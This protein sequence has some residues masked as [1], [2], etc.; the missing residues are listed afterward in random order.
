MTNMIGNVLNFA[1]GRGAGLMCVWFLTGN[2]RN[3]LACRWIA[4][5]GA[6]EA[7]EAVARSASLR[8]NAG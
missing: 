5:S 2:H 4:V 1:T 8:S 6:C 3:P 7:N